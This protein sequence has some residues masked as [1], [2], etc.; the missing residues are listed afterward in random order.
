[1][2]FKSISAIPGLSAQLDKID[3][4][5]IDFLGLPFT[6]TYSAHDPTVGNLQI[7]RKVPAKDS[8]V[9]YSYPIPNFD[10]RISVSVSEINTG[11]HRFIVLRAK[12]ARKLQG[13]TVNA[14]VC[15]FDL[16]ICERFDDSYIKD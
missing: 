4:Q 13:S 12:Y 14:K 8:K 1:M 11:S 3:S 7:C 6:D 9:L 16:S 2:L 10:S 5:R 15:F